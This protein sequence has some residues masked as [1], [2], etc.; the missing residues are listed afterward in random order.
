LLKVAGDVV[1]T[2]CGVRQRVLQI[3]E[4]ADIESELASASRRSRNPPT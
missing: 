4:R 1:D 3:G 2:S